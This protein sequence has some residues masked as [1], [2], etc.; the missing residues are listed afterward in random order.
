LE[1]SIWFRSRSKRPIKKAIKAENGSSE[2]NQKGKEKKN[3]FT[4]VCKSLFRNFLERK[5][6]ISGKWGKRNK[7][8]IFEREIES[9]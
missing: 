2:K 1:A 9:M 4:F 8:K 6:K 5:L 3:R 7:P